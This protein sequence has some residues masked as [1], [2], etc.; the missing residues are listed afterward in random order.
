MD[1]L[2]IMHIG[3]LFPQTHMLCRSPFLIPLDLSLLVEAMT[4]LA[5]MWWRLLYFCR[6]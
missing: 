1:R 2:S 4:Y 6:V 5:E 3:L